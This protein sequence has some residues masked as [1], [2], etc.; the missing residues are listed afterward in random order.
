MT[1]TRNRKLFVNLPVRDLK[2]SV[3]FFTRLGFS[4]DPRFTDES[5]TCM[6]IGE[7]AYA[8]LMVQQRF[9]D[10]VKRP[11]AD[12]AS[13]TGAIFALT[14]SSRGEVDE[15]MQVVVDAGGS[16][17]A[18]PVDHGFMYVRSFYDLDGHHWELFYM[19]MSAMP[20]E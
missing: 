11:I 19:D 16:P 6:L 13:A 2:R 10:F 17:A 7:D 12:S 4:F 1:T 15:L 3:E 18:D 14:A 8:M 9:K 20:Q 5:A